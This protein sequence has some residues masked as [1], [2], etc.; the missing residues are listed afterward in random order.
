MRVN[1]DLV[2][3][4]GKLYFCRMKSG[5]VSL[6]CV[7]VGVKLTAASNAPSPNYVGGNLKVMRSEGMDQ[8]LQDFFTMVFPSRTE[9]SRTEQ[10]Q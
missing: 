3:I 4:G 5:I 8:C 6:T 7:G 2:S 1:L 10:L 9:H